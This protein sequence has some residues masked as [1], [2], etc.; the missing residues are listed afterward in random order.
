MSCKEELCTVCKSIT[1][2]LVEKMLMFFKTISVPAAV[3][4]LAAVVASAP[5][6]VS[7]VVLTPG[8]TESELNFAWQTPAGADTE[9]IIQVALFAGRRYTDRRQK[10]PGRR[11]RLAGYPGKSFAN[12]A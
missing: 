3:L 1:N 2:R 11:G 9:T 7:N 6:D 10:Y 12:N 5:P 8:R 4:L